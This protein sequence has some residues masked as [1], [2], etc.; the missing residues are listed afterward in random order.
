MRSKEELTKIVLY[1]FGLM[2]LEEKENVRLRT[3]KELD[4]QLTRLAV[5]LQ[6]LEPKKEWFLQ[7]PENDALKLAEGIENAIEFAEELK[8]LLEIINDVLGNSL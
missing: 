2:T 8:I 4:E 1:N 5:V 3:E 6:A 7:L